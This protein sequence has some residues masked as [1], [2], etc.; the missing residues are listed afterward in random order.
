MPDPILDELARDYKGK[1]VVGKL[2]VDSNRRT[3]IKYGI[4]S[5]PTILVF[6]ESQLV[7]RSKGYAQNYVGI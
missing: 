1:I 5:I 6:K 3:A 4:T 2:N 7:D